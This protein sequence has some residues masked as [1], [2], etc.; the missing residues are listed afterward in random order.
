MP[1]DHYV[2]QVH[3]RKFYSPQLGDRFYAIRK[4]DLKTFTPNAKVVCAINDGS[5]N[6]Y[7]REDRAIEEFLKTIEPN[8]N[9]AVEKLATG[10]VDTESVY[11]I[12]GF[13]AYVALCAPAA[14]R[15]HSE[16]LKVNLEAT[17][18]LLD[19]QGLI[20]PSPSALGG[21]TLSELLDSNAVKFTVDPKYPQALGIDTIRSRTAMFGNFEWEVLHNEADD[22]PFFTSDFP[23]ALEATADPRQINRV[24]PLSPNLAV[25]IKPNTLLDQHQVDFS[26]RH[27]MYRSYAI[28]RS[29]AIEINRLLVRAAEET[30]FYRDD[31]PWVCPFV[32]KNRL[33]R[34]EAQTSRIAT[35]TGELMIS[36]Q[37]VVAI[38]AVNHNSP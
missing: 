22:C 26:F 25:R 7:L 20:P 8:Y 3:L 1:L 15:I 38:P 27:F 10:K 29:E 30:V 32:K 23:I 9:T 4:S 11:T 24:V 34:V 31:R 33:F 18:A 17:A 35:P 37:K 13:V 36:T 12:S 28:R 2:P 19:A 21:K 5:T 16:P 14:M 6:A